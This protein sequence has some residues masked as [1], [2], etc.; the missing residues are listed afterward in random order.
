MTIHEF[1]RKIGIALGVVLSE[2]YELDNH[3]GICEEIVEYIET[4]VVTQED[5]LA[6]MKNRHELAC[7]DHVFVD[8]AQD[9]HEIEKLFLFKFFGYQKLVI[10]DGVDQFVRGIG[11]LDWGKNVYQVKVKEKRSL[12]QERNLVGFVNSFAKESNLNWHVE[13]VPE[14]L[15]GNV[16]ISSELTPFDIFQ[17]VRD[18]CYSKGNKAFEILFLTPPNL[19]EN[20]AGKKR[21]FKLMQQFQD[22]GFYLWDGTQKDLRSSA[23][24][25]IDQHRLL[26]YDSCRGLEGWCIVCLG[27]DDFINYKRETFLRENKAKNQSPDL[28]AMDSEEMCKHFVGLWSLIPLTRAIDTIVI[29]LS[30]PNGP[31][32]ESLRRCANEDYVKFHTKKNP[33]NL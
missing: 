20:G 25:K 33:P 28:I 23:P 13:S 1:T 6:L 31:V 7:W 5:L 27:F 24:L 18:Q 3:I 9:F 2:D 30:S 26:Q 15:G 19:V 29:T 16:I 14:L 12:R 22:Q 17:E 21:C 32:A 10:S 11:H 8:E 4:G